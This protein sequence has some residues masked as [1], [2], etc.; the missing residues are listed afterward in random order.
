MVIILFLQF[1]NNNKMERIDEEIPEWIENSGFAKKFYHDHP[2]QNFLLEQWR[3]FEFPE[4]LTNKN[5]GKTLDNIRTLKITDRKY[6]YPCYVFMMETNFRDRIR[7][8]FPEFKKLYNF[9]NKLSCLNSVQDGNVYSLMYAHKH[10]NEINLNV[11]TEAIKRGDKECI[12]YCKE[13][14]KPLKP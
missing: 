10:G 4:V 1:F 6:I 11:Y 9:K 13:N 14:L 12:A 2:N 7:E 5:I 3:M 8:D